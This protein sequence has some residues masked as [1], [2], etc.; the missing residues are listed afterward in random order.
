MSSY[1][2][3]TR[4]PGW[5]SGGHWVECQRTGFVIRNEDAR[6]EWTGIIVAKEE[7]EPRHPQDFLRGVVD[8]QAAVGLVVPETSGTFISGGG[9][10]AVVGIMVVGEAVIGT[11]FT[12][13]NPSG[14]FAYPAG[15]DAIS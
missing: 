10:I 7:W 11:D 3:K 5:K 6:K 4:N 2:R 1:G 15:H 9:D 14:S 13:T 8:N 12:S